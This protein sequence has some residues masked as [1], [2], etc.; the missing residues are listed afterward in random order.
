MQL[1]KATGFDSVLEKPLNMQALA[2]W[3]GVASEAFKTETHSVGAASAPHPASA[4]HGE[5]NSNT[6]DAD[7][8]V[9]GST[10][11]TKPNRYPVCKPTASLLNEQQI[12]EDLEY[13]GADAIAEMLTL[14]KASSTAQI[15]ALANLPANSSELLHGLKGSSASMGLVALTQLCQQLETCTFTNEE[16]QALQQL[17]QDSMDTVSVKLSDASR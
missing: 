2:G 3:I 17:W 9:A 4:Y 11:K 8:L 1:Y 16:Y 14:F 10:I 7:S 6:T 13:L 15:A 5:V 12:T